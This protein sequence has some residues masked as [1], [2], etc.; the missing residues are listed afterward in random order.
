MLGPIHLK[1]QENSALSSNNDPVRS[2]VLPGAR[3]YDSSVIKQS[4]YAANQ[5]INEIDKFHQTG[6]TNNRNISD[7]YSPILDLKSR[8]PVKEGSELKKLTM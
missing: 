7:S 1:K 5:S 2:G 6:D 3:S 4:N 8:M